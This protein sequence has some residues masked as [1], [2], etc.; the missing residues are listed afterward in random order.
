MTSSLHTPG[1]QQAT[2]K[3]PPN[4]HKAMTVHELMRRTN[5]RQLE[6]DSVQLILHVSLN[7]CSCGKMSARS[8]GQVEA[9]NASTLTDE[10]LPE[11][12]A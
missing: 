10:V 7:L 6:A 11:S 9:R 3:A 12:S 5:H 1:A 2:S 4:K 8:A